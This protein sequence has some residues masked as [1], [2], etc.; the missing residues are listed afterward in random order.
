MILKD[1]FHIISVVFS[2][3]SLVAGNVFP[4][5]YHVD[6]EDS[7]YQELKGYY[8][9]ENETENGKPIFKKPRLKDYL[10]S[11]DKDGNWKIEGKGNKLEMDDFG[12]GEP[13]SGIWVWIY[14]DM[15][16][17]LWVDVLQSGG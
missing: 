9:R 16:M 11:V 1:Y 15:N 5:F 6:F 17:G 13:E 12:K 7:E 8:K 2:T 10:L 14:Q 3:S 4:S